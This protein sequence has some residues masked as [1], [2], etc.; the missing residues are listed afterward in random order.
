MYIQQCILTTATTSSS[1]ATKSLNVSRREEDQI[2]G[3]K[4][5]DVAHV[6]ESYQAIEFRN[7]QRKAPSNEVG[8]PRGLKEKLIDQIRAIQAGWRNAQATLMYERAKFHADCA[9]RNIR[10]TKDAERDWIRIAVAR[11]EVVRPEI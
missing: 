4:V 10:T 9:A 5:G 8:E 1:F 3:T 2:R 6:H 7:C 11:A